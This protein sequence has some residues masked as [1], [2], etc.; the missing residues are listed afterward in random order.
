MDVVI[1]L[2]FVSLILVAAALVFFVSR[3]KSG[4]FDH[5]ARLSL[6]PLH[7]DDGEPERTP[8]S[9]DGVIDGER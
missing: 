5:G 6:L 2:V 4:D 8:S 9:E 7:D 1:F 3:L